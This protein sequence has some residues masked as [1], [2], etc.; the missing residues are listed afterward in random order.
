MDTTNV[1]A[2]DLNYDHYA[3]EKYDRDIVNSIPHHKE[4]HTEIVKYVRKNFVANKIYSVLDLG[5]GTGLTSKLIQLELPKTEFDLVDF[6]KKMLDGAKK[7]LGTKK[8]NYIFGDY[9]KIKFKKKYDIIV[10]V[11]GIHHQNDKGKSILFK[12]IAS[13]LKPGG[14]FIF[15][16]LVTYKDQKIAAL[17]QALHFHHLV[18]KSTDAK[19]LKEWAHHHLFLNNLATIEDQ[20]EWLN[21]A[22]LKTKII[23]LKT[24]TALIICTKK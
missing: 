19:T 21:G 4:L 22:G 5:V 18:E 24:N 7:R 10:S 17:N 8:V 23:L 16:D 13:L 1:K 6:S 9:S 15:G 11:I 3:T 2:K 20:I 14:V 12:K